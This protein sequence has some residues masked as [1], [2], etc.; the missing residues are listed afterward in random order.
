MRIFNGEKIRIGGDNMLDVTA[1]G[2]IL[3]DFTP[4][5]NSDAQ[6]VSFVRNPGGAPANVLACL[7]KLGKKTAFIGK[8]GQD[9]F[10]VFLKDVLEQSRI[11]TQGLVFS[12]ETNTTLAF[13]HLNEQ[14][15]RSF[16]F[17]R[18][19]GADMML[20][21][22]E[23]DVKLIADSKV[24]H[25]GSISMTHEPSATATLK[26]LN[27]AKEKGCLISYDPNLRIPLWKDLSFA[28]QQIELG[29]S[30]ADV[31]KISEEELEFITGLQDLE[32]GSQYIYEH[33][34]VK[35]IFVT[36]GPEGCYYRMGHATGMRKGYAV[37]AVDTTGAGDSFLAGILYQILNSGNK[38]SELTM[39]ELEPM[40]GFANA[41][42][43]LAT[44]KKGAIPAMPTLEEIER[45]M[46]G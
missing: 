43:A 23:V 39:N 44:T 18:N 19:P 11:E 31:L 5:A 9:Q 12:E 35:L 46:R 6:I 42:G 33:Y 37:S 25:F 26:A 27:Y 41:V 28:K 34:H 45:L 30:Y 10:G 15:D 40:V 22:D 7:A 20:T 4:A 2:E 21:A 24:F 14:G 17:Y 36:L 32:A 16:S 8:V 29:L 3:I 38:I 1:L 13:V